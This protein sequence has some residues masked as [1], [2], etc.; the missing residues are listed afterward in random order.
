ML[1]GKY[2]FHPENW[3]EITEDAKDLIRKLL[4]VDPAKRLT[5]QQVGEI[6]TLPALYHTMHIHMRIP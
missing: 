6:H 3:N 2:E 5:A 4:V 1:L